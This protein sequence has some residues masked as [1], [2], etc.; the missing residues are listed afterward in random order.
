MATE[1]PP[2]GLQAI[3]A[4]MQDRLNNL[5]D[6]ANRI[7]RAIAE[8]NGASPTAIARAG[9]SA[10]APQA[11]VHASTGSAVVGKPKAKPAKKRA[12]RLKYGPGSR[13]DRV[14]TDLRA[15]PESTTPDIAART[16]I[17]QTS[18]TKL[19]GQLRGADLV[20][21]TRGTGRNELGHH[22][23]VGGTP[24]P[25]APATPANGATGAP[26]PAP[27]AAK[28]KAKPKATSKP[29]T[30]PSRQERVLADLAAH[31]DTRG[32]DLAERIGVRDTDV[33]NILRPLIDAGQ[34]LRDTKPGNKP[35]TF[36]LA[37][38][39]AEQTPDATDAT[40]TPVATSSTTP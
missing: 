29:R 21:T 22:R 2:S 39:A 40:P 24:A 15:H 14:L 23:V 17:D 3:I 28:A 1:E 25:P 31:P 19:I 7:R 26:K 10:A 5:D 11:Q 32:R 34:V 35:S 9:L 33:Y 8:L 13:L 37:A 4:V 36:R 18:V 6:E 20:E 16:N 30:G 38:P 12:K 27:A